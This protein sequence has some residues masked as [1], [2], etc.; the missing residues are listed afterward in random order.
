MDENLTK[1]L[2]IITANELEN[3]STA[4]NSKD[5]LEKCEM[6]KIKWIKKINVDT[7]RETGDLNDVSK[8]AQ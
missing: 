6:L 2:I 7:E 8:L 4:N 3:F 5:S 1:K